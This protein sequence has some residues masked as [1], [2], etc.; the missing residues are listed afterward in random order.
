MNYFINSL[1]ILRSDIV[2]LITA[3]KI[4]LNKA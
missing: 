2:Y 4:D 1:F 3:I